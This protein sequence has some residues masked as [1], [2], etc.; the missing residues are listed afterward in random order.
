MHMFCSTQSQNSGPEAQGSAGVRT[1]RSAAP[2][3]S[4]GLEQAAVTRRQTAIFP[5]Q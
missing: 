5:Q 1:Q 4:A 3:P 2:L